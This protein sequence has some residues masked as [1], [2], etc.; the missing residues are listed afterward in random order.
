MVSVGQECI[1]V[2]GLAASS[3]HGS[4]SR[5]PRA[6]SSNSKHEVERKQTRNGKTKLSSQ[7]SSD[8]LLLDRALSLSYPRP[9]K[10]IH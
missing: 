7:T 9:P 2:G 8:I 1:K 4:W 3:R 10:K 6:S 5:K